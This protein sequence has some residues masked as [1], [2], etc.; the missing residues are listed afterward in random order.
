MIKDR[1]SMNDLLLR[2]D[3]KALSSVPGPPWRI[4]CDPAW[5]LKGG[6][7]LDR[8]LVIFIGI[9]A[10]DYDNPIWSLYIG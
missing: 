8:Q 10:M 6:N 2:L 3:L 7:R 5:D 1:S 4:T 9:P